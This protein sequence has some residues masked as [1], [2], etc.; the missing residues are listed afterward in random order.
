[1][2][3]TA[4]ILVKEINGMAKPTITGFINQGF[5]LG[6]ICGKGV[7]SISVIVKKDELRKALQANGR[8][9]VFELELSPDKRITVMVKEIQIKP[10]HTDYHHVDFQQ[11]SLTTKVK[12]S[13]SLLFT[14]VDVLESKRLL[15]NKHFDTLFVSGLPQDIPDKFTIDVSELKAG[16]HVKISD[17][18]CSDTII[19]ELP[20]DTFVLSVNE[21][22]TYE[23]VETK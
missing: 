17:L 6:N 22:K 15:L 8:N 23:E 5:V 12:S 11:I 16:D 14:G 9:S 3:K 1:M 20:S 21:A 10:L 7:P 4:V 2:S 18:N 13:V 19:P